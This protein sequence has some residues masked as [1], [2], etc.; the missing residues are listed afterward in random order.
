MPAATLQEGSQRNKYARIHPSPPF[1]LL[2]EHNQKLEGK[3][4]LHWSPYSQVSFPGSQ[5]GG[6][7]WEVH[8]W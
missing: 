1:S 5:Q 8:L 4:H 2:V 6:K 3:R 7:D